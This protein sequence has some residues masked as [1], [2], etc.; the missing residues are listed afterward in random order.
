MISYDEKNKIFQIDT[1]HTSYLIGIADKEQFLGSIYY[2]KRIRPGQ[3][4]SCLMGI[5]DAPFTPSVNKGERGSFYDVF[6]MEYPGSG[7]GDYRNGA[8]TVTNSYGQKDCQILYESYEIVRGK[9]DL[10]G[11]PH[12]FAGEDDRVDTLI[13]H[14]RDPYIGL[15]ADLFYSAFPSEDVITRSVKVRNEGEG[16]LFLNRVMSACLDIRDS[17]LDVLTLPGSW[18]RERKIERTALGNGTFSIGSRRGI[19]SHQYQ[20]FMALVSRGVTEDSGEVY[21]IHFVYSGSFLA[22]AEKDHYHHIRMLMGI[23]PDCFSWKLAAGEEFTA[24][25]AVMTYSN[26]GLGIMTRNLHHLYRRHLI[27]SPYLHRDRPVLINNWEATYFDFDEE[28]LLDIALE[29]HSLGIEMLVMDDGWFGHR[30]KENSSLGDWYVNR[31]R[32]P[33]GL[34]HLSDALHAMGMKFGIWM[35]PEMVSPDSDLYR[36]HP[37]WAIAAV[38]RP[39]TESRNQYVLDLS[40]SEVRDYVW[41]CIRNVLHSTRIEYLKWDMNRQLTDLGSKELPP[42]RQGELMHRYVLGVYDLQERLLKEFPDLLFENCTSGGGRY[43]PGMLYY[44]PQIWCSDDTDAGERLIIQEGTE[45]LYPLSTMGAHVSA[46]PNH[47]VGR[48]T[49]FQTRGD[50]ALAGTFGYELDVRKLSPEEKKMVPGQI[51]IYKRFAELIREG[52][53]YRLASVRENQIC[54]AWMLVSGDQS[55]AL[56]TYVQARAEAN[57]KSRF[58]K[59]AGLKPDQNY[60]I[61][62]VHEGRKDS[63]LGGDVLMSA[64]IRIPE[65]FGDYRSELIYLKEEC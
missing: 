48:V 45:L 39:G 57:E 40:R 6:P 11:L 44:S 64:G 5:E 23:H 25:E 9:P 35:E 34:G 49:P 14:C 60:N 18:A 3:N 7:V 27:L 42:D 10:P 33:N 22:S 26:S 4:L 1:D 59:L 13:L 46:C 30:L 43:D 28:K 65:L 2:G 56:L 37:D 41:N 31:D 61:E 47:I 54:D 50:V 15:Q 16:P 52:D 58:L 12:T 53:Y 32:L 62:W 21:A 17:D 24:P 63:C 55:E 36:Q 29:A 19:S 38:G 51:A 20:P 8:L